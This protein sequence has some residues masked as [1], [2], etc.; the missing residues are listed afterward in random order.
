MARNNNKIYV[1]VII[2]I[3]KKKE[4][5]EKEEFSLIKSRQHIYKT[6]NGP[7]IHGSKI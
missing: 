4:R 7:K 5:E 6:A 1:Y 3:K 2:V